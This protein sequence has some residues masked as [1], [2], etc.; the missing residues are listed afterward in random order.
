M[1]KQALTISELA[2]MFRTE[3]VGGIPFARI[4]N[5]LVADGDIRIEN[6]YFAINSIASGYVDISTIQAP[7]EADSS[8]VRQ[9][10]I[11]YA[12]ETHIY[13]YLATA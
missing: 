7:A 12:A 5:T 1:C 11:Y 9:F 8:H 10:R 13:I 3:K 2:G 6:K 4:I